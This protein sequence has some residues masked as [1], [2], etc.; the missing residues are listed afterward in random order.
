MKIVFLALI[1]VLS[2]TNTFAQSNCANREEISKISKNK[3]FS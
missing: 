2:A 1:L 3:I